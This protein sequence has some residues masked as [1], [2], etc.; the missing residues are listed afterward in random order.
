[1]AK[2]PS[3]EQLWAVEVDDTQSVSTSTKLPK[4]TIN[5]TNNEKEMDHNV[6]DIKKKIS[7]TNSSTITAKKK[8]SEPDTQEANRTLSMEQSSSEEISST[9]PS[10]EQT[11]AFEVEA[12]QT[13]ST[14]TKFPEAIKIIDFV[15]K[16]E[17]LKLFVGEER[18]V[19]TFKFRCQA[20][21]PDKTTKCLAIF[22]KGCSRKK[23]ISHLI[24]VP[25]D[26][27]HHTTNT[28]EM[29]YYPD[30]LNEDKLRVPKLKQLQGRCN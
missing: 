11:P 21:K 29:L 3:E 6:S 24:G 4:K 27:L 1:M 20:L 16:L 23:Y 15:K 26:K 13:V 10:D 19:A 7:K 8:V 30:D 2:K 9:R 12:P 17:N 25:N 14:S 18:M 28:N 22:N 5:L